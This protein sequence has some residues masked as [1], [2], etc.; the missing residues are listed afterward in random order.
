MSLILDNGVVFAVKTSGAISVED[1]PLIRYL[2]FQEA[3]F[4]TIIV[5]PETIGELD[6][7][8]HQLLGKERS[9]FAINV[10]V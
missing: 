9:E 2:N 3:E 4:G 6:N 7:L 10:V 1:V 5:D 8:L